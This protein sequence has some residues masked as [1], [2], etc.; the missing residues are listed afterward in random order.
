MG[1]LFGLPAP[2]MLALSLVKRGR[3]I[4]VGAPVLIAWQALEATAATR[5]LRAAP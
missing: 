5:R 4:V 1:P 3:D 2:D